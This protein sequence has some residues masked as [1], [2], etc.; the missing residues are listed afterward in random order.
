MQSETY[1]SPRKCQVFLNDT[2][3][4]SVSFFGGGFYLNYHEISGVRVWSCQEIYTFS[5]FPCSSEKL[6]WHVG[7]VGIKILPSGVNIGYEYAGMRSPSPGAWGGGFGC[8]W[9]GNWVGFGV[10]LDTGW[11]KLGKPRDAK[12][13]GCSYKILL[14]KSRIVFWGFSQR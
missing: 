1:S 13:T 4:N 6:K 11:R 8:I 5:Y 3:F 7:A 9:I 2:M 14:Y 12:C 10:G